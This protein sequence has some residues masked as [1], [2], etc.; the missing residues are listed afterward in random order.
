MIYF[1]HI[2]EENYP[3]SAGAGLTGKDLFRGFSGGEFA[4]SY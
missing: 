4:R 1:G 3:M 2:T